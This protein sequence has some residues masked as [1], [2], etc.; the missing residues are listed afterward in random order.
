MGPGELGHVLW[1]GIRGT[2]LPCKEVNGMLGQ[3][4]GKK[5]KLA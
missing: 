1:N 3:Q 5:Q 2:A 4:G